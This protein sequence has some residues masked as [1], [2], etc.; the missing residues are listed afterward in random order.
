M[1]KKIEDLTLDERIFMVQKEMPNIVK[2]IPGYNYKYFDINQ[3]IDILSPF[4]EK[5]KLLVTQPLVHIEGKPAIM[6]RIVM[7]DGPEDS[8][9]SMH[10]ITPIPTIQLAGNGQQGTD[11]QKYGASVTYMRRY[12]LVSWFMLQAEK[13]TDGT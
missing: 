4:L 10:S 8:E 2:D 9:T 7:L 12:S 1:P 3:L 5:Y 6:T 13:D 11:P